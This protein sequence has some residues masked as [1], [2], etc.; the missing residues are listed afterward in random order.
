MGDYCVHHVRTMLQLRSPRTNRAVVLTSPTSGAGKTTLS[1]A[2]GMSFAATG[3]RTLLVDLDFVGH[4]LTSA[5][6]GLVCELAT[7]QLASRAAAADGTPAKKNGRKSPTALALAA[8]RVTVTM[9][10]AHDVLAAAREAA[11]AG[12]ESAAQAVEA[13]EAL[14]RSTSNGIL[15]A[16]EPRIH[17]GAMAALTGTPLAS[18]VVPTDVPGLTLLPVG[19][20]SAKDAQCLS[21]ASIE[22]LVAECRA[23]YDTIIIDTGPVLG[24]LEAALVGA[25]ADEVLLVVARGERQPLVDE[26]QAR[27]AQIGADVAG[28]V[29]NR[30]TSADVARSSY[31]SRSASVHVAQA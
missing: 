29:F 25:V 7:A 19:D 16:G 22:R 28:V 12:D 21:P 24:S 27:L 30:A 14:E 13:L 8:R 6:R 20:A 10:E 26:A 5:M 11:A 3:Q 9:R 17:R 23:S 4:G 18:C 15:D 31:S 1:M 2:L